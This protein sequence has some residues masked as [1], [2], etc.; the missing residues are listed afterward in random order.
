MRQTLTVAAAR[1]RMERCMGEPNLWT[2]RERQ[3][4]ALRERKA[5]GPALRQSGVEMLKKGEQR[6]GEKETCSE[7]RKGILE[8]KR[9]AAAAVGETDAN[10]PGSSAK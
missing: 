2:E 9:Q 8:V 3:P 1:E 10:G 6:K 4:S 5:I 7:T